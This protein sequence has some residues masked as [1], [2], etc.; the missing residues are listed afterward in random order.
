MTQEIDKDEEPGPEMK[1]QPRPTRANHG[2]EK[3]DRSRRHVLPPVC[4]ILSQREKSRV[5][6][7]LWV[8]YYCKARVFWFRELCE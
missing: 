8:S 2:L 6:H 5:L 7:H 3:P 1:S 4:V